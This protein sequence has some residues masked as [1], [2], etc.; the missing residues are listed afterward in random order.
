MNIQ[1]ISLS[2]KPDEVISVGKHWLWMTIFSTCLFASCGETN[3]QPSEPTLPVPQAQ[4]VS[5]QYEPDIIPEKVVQTTD[6]LD[7]EGFEEFPD[8]HPEDLVLERFIE[9]ETHIRGRRN[10]W[11]S[12]ALIQPR[13]FKS[14]P[15]SIY[16]ANG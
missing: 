8:P 2:M 11:S 6:H 12:I 9:E 10:S 14:F 15:F 5:F 1:R 13:F 4:A 7:L 3:R 16:R